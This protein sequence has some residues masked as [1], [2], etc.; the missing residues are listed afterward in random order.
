MS[1]EIGEVDDD[2]SSDVDEVSGVEFAAL[3]PSVFVAQH[4][5]SLRDIML[6]ISS[7]TIPQTMRKNT[8]EASL[9]QQRP[10]HMLFGAYTSRTGGVGSCTWS[11]VNELQDCE[12]GWHRDIRNQGQTDVI[13]FGKYT[14]RET[15]RSSEVLDSF[16]R[17]SVAFYVPQGVDRLSAGDWD[18]L[19]KH[20]FPVKEFWASQQP[21][22]FRF[23]L[24]PC[25]CDAWQNQHL[26][27]VAYA[28]P[29]T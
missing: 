24:N 6:D 16:L 1:C 7:W 4:V 23:M 5:R 28:L 12:L 17:I 15:G 27:P 14:E 25:S 29:D 9:T 8:Y 19:Q 26:E 11:R 13:A 21:Q 20:D 10:R 22:R 3:S 2:E 18:L